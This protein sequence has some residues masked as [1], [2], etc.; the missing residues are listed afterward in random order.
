MKKLSPTRLAI[1]LLLGILLTANGFF[2]AI[3][4]ISDEKPLFMGIRYFN[5]GSLLLG[6][7]LLFLVWR[8]SNRI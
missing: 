6:S 1:I 5:W 3:L 7:L 4:Y 8:N 2:H